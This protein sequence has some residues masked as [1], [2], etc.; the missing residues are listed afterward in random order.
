MWLS[1]SELIDLTG[2]KKPA[3][4]VRWLKEKRIKHFVRRDGRPIVLIANLQPQG[5][6]ERTELGIVS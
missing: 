6:E 2:Y 3:C 1:E 5:K 4:Q